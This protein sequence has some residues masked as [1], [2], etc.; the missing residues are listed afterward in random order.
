MNTIDTVQ[1]EAVSGGGLVDKAFGWGVG[2]ILRKRM[3]A[4]E[5]ATAS[6]GNGFESSPFLDALA[7]G[8]Q[9]A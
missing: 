2:Y 8:N 1:C 4:L 7:A 6:P 3:D 9:T 5:R